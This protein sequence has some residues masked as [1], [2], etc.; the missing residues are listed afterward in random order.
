MNDILD[1]YPQL[2]A[3]PLAMATMCALLRDQGLHDDALSLAHAAMKAAPDSTGIRTDVATTLTIGVPIFH[4]P[5]LLDQARN[6]AYANAI[7]R[8]VKP[9]M[10]VLEI[11]SGAGLLAML[12]AR[13]GARVVTC[14]EHPVI[15]AAAAQIIERNGL[16]D[17]ITLIRKRSTL[18]TVPEDLPYPADLVIHEIFGAKLFCEGVTAALT[19][20]RERLLAPCAPSLPPRARVRCALVTDQLAPADIRLGDVEGFDLSPFEVFSRPT[21]ALRKQKSQR[22]RPVA[23]PVSGMCMDYDSPPPFGPMSETLIVESHG[24]RIDGIV[25]WIALDFGNGEVLENDPFTEGPE[26]SWGVP[27]TPLVKPIETIPGERLEIRLRR[28]GT[29]LTADVSRIEA[30]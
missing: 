7:E 25:Q 4:L 11:G 2:R 16:A 27:Y 15:A 8:M 26:S 20:A 3:N 19:D 21:I 6:Q 1:R 10:L 28:R 23:D 29:L 30:A 17:R 13:A 5:M 12:C 22:L 9:G 24:G 18:L 14:E